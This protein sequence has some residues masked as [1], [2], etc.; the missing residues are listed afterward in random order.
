[1]AVLFS[2]SL[3]RDAKKLSHMMRL[4]EEMRDLL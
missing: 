2:K 1:M 4:I 3:S